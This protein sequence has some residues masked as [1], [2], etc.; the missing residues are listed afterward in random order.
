MS[1]SITYFYDYVTK[2]K[3]TI[4]G[5]R[6]KPLLKWIERTELVKHYIISVLLYKV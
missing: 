3:F 2:V 5:S 4:I 6:K 1:I